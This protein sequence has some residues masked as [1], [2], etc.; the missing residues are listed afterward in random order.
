M[1]ATFAETRD[2]L[3]RSRCKNSEAP[4]RGATDPI[5]V[6][7][8]IAVSLVL[9]VGGGFAVQGLI[10]NGQDSNAK[11]DLDKAAVAQES[12]VTAV[13]EVYIYDNH[14]DSEYRALEQPPVKS[15]VIGF[16]PTAGGRLI[17]DASVD[18][19]GDKH[20]IAVSHSRSGA[21]FMRTS[22]SNAIYPVGSA[23]VYAAGPQSFPLE[24]V[25]IP[26]SAKF[27]EGFGEADVTAMMDAIDGDYPYFVFADLGEVPGYGEPATPGD[28]SAGGGD[29]GGGSADA[30]P[31]V[32]DG[33]IPGG[34]LTGSSPTP[35]A[36]VMD[37]GD[38]GFDILGQPYG[39][40]MTSGEYDPESGYFG[41]QWEGSD[42]LP[43]DVD[44]A[45]FRSALPVYQ[46]LY[47]GYYYD[48]FD[49]LWDWPITEVRAFVGGKRIAI[50][51]T[52][53]QFTGSNTSEGFTN[54]DLYAD[55]VTIGAPADDFLNAS[56]VQINLDGYG[57]HTFN[58]N[59]L[60]NYATSDGDR[61][62]TDM[63]QFGGTTP[64]VS[65]VDT[66]R[67]ST[68]FY[69]RFRGPV[70]PQMDLLGPGTYTPTG[71]WITL[72]DGL[73]TTFSASTMSGAFLRVWET[74]S[75]NP[76]GCFSQWTEAT[77]YELRMQQSLFTPP[78]Y[79]SSM[80][81]Q[82]LRELLDRATVTAL[83]NGVE[84]EFKMH[85]SANTGQ[86]V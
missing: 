35:A 83:I 28:N 34:G 68:G 79:T 41:I 3:R 75:T 25:T 7:A 37:N 26:E 64:Y 19:D 86:N 47:P 74:T 70:M 43:F 13:E 30:E 14:R 20:W 51:G 42:D 36:G 22:E 2:R 55:D 65:Q 52:N 45:P 31:I 85:R 56:A 15:A 82:E 6:I 67:A 78:G 12:V 50:D 80:T 17:V 8:A 18:A 9:L 11:G 16:E 44:A 46:G 63:D 81:R 48:E 58:L 66:I 73:N 5:L 10:T 33:P 59:G 71:V 62:R 32:W 23:Q 4:D 57:W 69:A 40:E 61:F 72:D 60:A 39:V 24:V 29:S 49:P 21:V 27:P 1:L 53:W 38:G 54:F 76:C 84:Y 77:R